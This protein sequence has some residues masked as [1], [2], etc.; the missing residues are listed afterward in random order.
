[1]KGTDMI[2]VSLDWNHTLIIYNTTLG[3]KTNLTNYYLF[4]I[5]FLRKYAFH[6]RFQQFNQVRLIMQQKVD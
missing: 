3:K 1:M 5:Q 2:D 6:Q 4:V